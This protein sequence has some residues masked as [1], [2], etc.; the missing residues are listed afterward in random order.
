LPMAFVRFTNL[1]ASANNNNK[2]IIKVFIRRQQ[3]ARNIH[4][5]TQVFYT[6]ST[7]TNIHNIST[8]LT[9]IYK[10]TPR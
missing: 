6:I 3:G 4:I 1:P 7:H 5:L 2:I 10:D 9:N 8:I